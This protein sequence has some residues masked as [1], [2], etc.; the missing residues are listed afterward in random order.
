MAR[1][2]LGI[3]LSAP[4]IDNWGEFEI[5]K[6]YR[7]VPPMFGYVIQT[8]ERTIDA[9]AGRLPRAR[10]PQRPLTTSEEVEDFT[11]EQ[12]KNASGIYSEVFPIINGTTCF[13]ELTADRANCL[14]D[15]FAGGAILRYELSSPPPKRRRGA[16]EPPE[17]APDD[18]PP[19]RGVIRMV[20]KNQFFPSDEATAR[21]I[22]RAIQLEGASPPLILQGVEWSLNPETPANGLPYNADY[23]VLDSQA[24]H[25]VVVTWTDAGVTTVNSNVVRRAGG[26][27]ETH[28]RKKLRKYT[29]KAR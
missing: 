15:Q 27:R 1:P 5:R 17:W 10:H 7:V 18:D 4:K 12:V 13:G 14:D 29:R 26:R 8:V 23:R 6:T 21:A 9:S 3:D 2:R 11:N 24:T 28:R 19:S 22:V 16:P 25:N 20:G